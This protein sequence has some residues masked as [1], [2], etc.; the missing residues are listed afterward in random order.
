MRREEPW[1]RSGRPTV[2]ASRGI[3]S[4][5]ILSSIIHYLL[6]NSPS[7]RLRTPEDHSANIPQSCPIETLLPI[8]PVTRTGRR[9][10]QV[11][12]DPYLRQF[13]VSQ[14][15]SLPIPRPQFTAQSYRGER[16]PMSPWILWS[17]RKL[18]QRSSSPTRRRKLSHSKSRGDDDSQVHRK[19]TYEI[20]SFIASKLNNYSMHN[21]SSIH[22]WPSNQATSSPIP[23]S[24]SI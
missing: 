2:S 4:G 24:N 11:P 9:P 20:S 13:P 3:H 19:I 23:S 21:Y 8:R 7:V 5:Q 6:P 10:S 1:C 17:A 22:I 18:V 16:R 14:S 12:L 15:Q